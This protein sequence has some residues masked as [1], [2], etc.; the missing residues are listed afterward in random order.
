M[1][2]IAR[3]AATP[4]V[5]LI[6]LD[7]PTSSLGPERSQQLRAYVHAQAAKG[8]SFI[9][10][11]HKLF[12]I[13]DVAMRV[14]VL[15]NGRLVW[16]G[17]SKNVGVPDLVRDDG[18]R[19]RGDCRAPRARRR[20]FATAAVRVRIAGDVVATLGRDMELREGEVVGLAG[21]EGSGQKELLHRIFSPSRGKQSTIARNG[22]ASFVSGDRLREGVFPLWSVLANIGLGQIAGLPMFRLLSRRRA[23]DGS[24][25]RRPSACGWMSID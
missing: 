5:K 23:N 3:V 22:E 7:E 16:H 15:R 12:E 19:S 8:V 20:I 25:R 14:A 17:D 1:V 11:S 4:D 18:R 24:C 2:E 21:L 6:I 10:I 9:F 13:V